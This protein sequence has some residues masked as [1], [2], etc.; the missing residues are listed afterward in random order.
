MDIAKYWKTIFETISDG[1]M[2][3]DPVGKI[4]AI[5]PAGEKLTG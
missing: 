4:L 2:I 5:N 3:V 1:L